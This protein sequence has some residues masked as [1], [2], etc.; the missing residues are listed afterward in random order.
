MKNGLEFLVIISFTFCSYK[1]IQLDKCIWRSSA[2]CSAYAVIFTSKHSR[3][4]DWVPKFYPMA[5]TITRAFFFRFLFVRSEFVLLLLPHSKI[6]ANK[7]QMN[8]AKSPQ[9]CSELFG[10]GFSKMSI[11]AWK[12]EALEDGEDIVH[13]KRIR[14]HLL[15]S[16]PFNFFID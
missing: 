10:N 1:A 7:S 16:L 14:S 6:Y 3:P 11:I 15:L 5:P 4:L 12:L 13:V 9:K 8:V 2:L